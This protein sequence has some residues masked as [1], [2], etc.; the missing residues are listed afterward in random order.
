MVTINRILFDE[1]KFY[2]SEGD[3]VEACF[4]FNLSVSENFKDFTL[5]VYPKLNLID[6]RVED[7]TISADNF[8]GQTAL[9]RYREEINLIIKEYIWT[10]PLIIHFLKA[11]KNFK[12]LIFSDMSIFSVKNNKDEDVIVNEIF[13]DTFAILN[14][15]SDYS[16]S[17]S[18]IQ[19][20]FKDLYYNFSF[21]KIYATQEEQKKLSKVKDIR[22]Q[23]LMN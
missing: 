5:Y 16:I 3:L 2:E 10:D 21:S 22:L 7:I 12:D 17:C 4:K 9:N 1:K 15:N 23:I 19:F 18:E 8:V 13:P 20:H 11:L 14:L 6:D